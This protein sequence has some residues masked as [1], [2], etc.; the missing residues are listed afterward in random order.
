MPPRSL[1]LTPPTQWLAKNQPNADNRQLALNRP[2]N[3]IATHLVGAKVASIIALAIAASI[4]FA[5]APQL[6]QGAVLQITDRLDRNEAFLDPRIAFQKLNLGNQRFVAGKSIHPRQ[7]QVALA[8][9]A[10]KQEPFAAIVACSDSR[11]PNEIVFDQGLGDLFVIRTAGQVAGEASFGTLEFGVAVLKTKLV[12][13]MGHTECGAVKA[14][15]DVPENPPGAISF[16]INSI[17]QAIEPVTSKEH[18]TLDEGIEANVLAQVNAIR[19]RQPVLS[20]AFKQGEIIVVGAVYNLSTGIVTY[21]PE[22]LKG[23]P[24]DPAVFDVTRRIIK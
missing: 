5:P 10:N 8:K 21:L 19:R 6:K 12:V 3:V 1:R 23:T 18:A 11:V 14:A 22:T 4:N 24:V 7:D 9:L 15:M 20:K 2:A 13:V 16:L 17:R